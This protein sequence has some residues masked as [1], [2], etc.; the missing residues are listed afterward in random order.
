MLV[1][2][3]EHVNV[4]TY[5]L[6][7]G[8]SRRS[9]IMH[10]EHTRCADFRER[11]AVGQPAHYRF[12]VPDSNYA[13]QEFLI[14]RFLEPLLILAKEVEPGRFFLLSEEED[15]VSIMKKRALIYA[16]VFVLPFVVI[17]PRMFNATKRNHRPQQ[18]IN[19][20]RV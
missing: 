7:E 9:L 17:A 8:G 13:S 4:F 1:D 10:G 15:Q 5:L 14:V 2:P 20:A 6:G 11:V 18:M 16:I 19:T 12:S 3:D